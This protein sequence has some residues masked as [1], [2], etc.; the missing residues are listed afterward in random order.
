[1]R[2]PSGEKRRCLVAK[3]VQTLLI[4]GGSSSASVQAGTHFGSMEDRP[5]AMKASSRRMSY[6]L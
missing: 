6:C 5:S 1:M 4:K 2:R 3:G